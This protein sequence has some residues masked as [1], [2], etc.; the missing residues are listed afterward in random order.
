MGVETYFNFLLLFGVLLKD[1][2]TLVMKLIKVFKNCINSPACDDEVEPDDDLDG[3]E[4]DDSYELSHFSLFSTES[5]SILDLIA[6]EA[7]VEVE[8]FDYKFDVGKKD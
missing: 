5:Q 6:K 1:T 3:T 4:G 8:E 7:S 2:L